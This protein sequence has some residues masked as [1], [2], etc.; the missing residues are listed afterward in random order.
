ML[1]FTRKT[2]INADNYLIQISMMILPEIGTLSSTLSA[3]LIRYR[4]R[5]TTCWHQK[6]S[7]FPHPHLTEVILHL[8]NKT[9]SSVEQC[10]QLNFYWIKK[11]FNWVDFQDFK[12]PGI[13]LLEMTLQ[14]LIFVD[15]IFALPHVTVLLCNMSKT[16]TLRCKHLYYEE[17]SPEYKFISQR[18]ITHIYR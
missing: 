7:L 9:Q 12:V 13:L 1:I 14:T 4:D 17:R 15:D 18:N 11:P 16:E 6:I 2:D 3:F 5:A 10:F 8:W